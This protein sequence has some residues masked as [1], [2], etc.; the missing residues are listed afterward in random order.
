MCHY[1]DF[2]KTAN[3][4]AALIER[5][6]GTL[7]SHARQWLWI[8]QETEGQSRFNSVFFG[9]GTPSLLAQEY[10]SL[11]EILK[12]HLTPDAELTLEANPD[13]LEP[14]K[15]SVWR[16]LG[17]NR[18]S[19][20]VQSFQQSGL[21]FLKRTHRS[22]DVY[23]GIRRASGFFDRISIDLIYGWP[24]Q[25]RQMWQDDLN[26][27]LSLPIEH[28]SLYHLTYEPRTPVGRAHDRGLFKPLS[29]DNIADYY[30]MAC[31]VLASKGYVQ[32]EVSNWCKPGNHCNQNIIYWAG[33]SYLGLG[34]GAHGYLAHKGLYGLRYH[35]PRRERSFRTGQKPVLSVYDEEEWVSSMGIEIDRERDHQAWLLERLGSSLRTAIGFNVTEAERV[36]RKKWR[37]P[38]FLS[39]AIGEGYLF[40]RTVGEQRSLVLAPNQWFLEQSWAQLILS[41][42][43]NMD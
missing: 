34:S 21:S 43:D 4:D 19:I 6:L 13:D 20:G 35:Y 10:S 40:W 25:T 32:Y 31:E 30:E 23:E 15:I 11:M 24:G 12:P 2:A 1:C 3:Y 37:D 39:E 41:A 9:G 16:D 5:Y 36:L 29:D 7:E 18:L 42:W 17:F 27:A 22:A 38:S 14:S 33:G 28:L 8:S 26:E